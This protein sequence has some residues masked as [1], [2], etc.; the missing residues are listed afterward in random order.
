MTGAI[1]H[2]TVYNIKFEFDFE[3]CSYGL[4]I[5]NDH[6]WFC[7]VTI[8]STSLF[9]GEWGGGSSFAL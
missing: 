3:L 5:I 7:F 4:V 2:C 8:K 9:P 6:K 1:A